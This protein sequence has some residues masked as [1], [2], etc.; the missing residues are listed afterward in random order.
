MVNLSP[1][2]DVDSPWNS[3]Y[4]Y[5]STSIRCF[6]HIHAWEMSGIPVM[7]TVGPMKGHLGMEEYKSAFTHEGEIAKAGYH[8]VFLNDYHVWA[9]LTSTC[10]V[11]MH[12][13]TFPESDAAYLIFDT[14]AFLANSPMDSSHVRKVSDTEI[15]GMSLMAPSFSHRRNNQAPVWFVAQF[16]KPMS[17]FGGWVDKQ[18]ITEP[19]DRVSGKDA[20]VYI[21]FH[22]AEGEQI[23]VKVAISYTGLEAAR[24]NLN[25]ELA[26]WDFDKV[27]EDSFREWEDELSHIRVSGGT[28]AQ[29]TKFYTDLWH[30]QLGRRTVSDVDGNY[31][32]HTGE[33]LRTGQA[34]LDRHGKPWAHH[35]YDSWWG[36]HW[37]LNILWSLA[38]PEVMDEFCNTMISMYKDGGL[39]DRGATGGNYSFVMIGDPSV[40]LFATAYNKGIRNYDTVTAY[41]A[42]RKNAFIGGDRDHAGYEQQY[43]ATGGGMK[44]Y[45][46]RGYV[47]YDRT[48]GVGFHN[49]ATSAM[50]LEYAYQDW[51]L[52]QIAKNMGKE[53]DYAYFTQRAQNYRNVWNPESRFMQPRL[54]DGSFLK[55]FNPAKGGRDIGF[56]EANAAIYSHYVPHDITGLM[57]LFGGQE[58]YVKR[59]N[60]Q[61]EK[62]QQNGFRHN[63]EIEFWTQYTNQPGT[64]MAHIFNFAGAPW[65][66]Q[67]WVRKV[68][69]AFSDITPYGG[70]YDDEDQGQMGALGVLLAIGLFEEDGGAAAK[71]TYE[72]TSPI[73]DK[74]EIA[75]NPDYYPGKTFSIITRNNS[76]ENMYIQSA[77]LNGEEWN[78]YWFSHET[79]ANGGTLELVLGPEPNYHWGVKE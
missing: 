8:K 70:Y 51:C 26:H 23:Q 75:L 13:Y 63:D 30:A 71:P 61:F 47:P 54:L 76:P 27:K 6:S 74:V 40:S 68:K 9:E 33:T 19:I 60:E 17:A 28:E 34:P 5:G 45:L 3:S 22:T 21:R 66:S 31:P 44:Y 16:D 11:G 15:E 58:T 57:E 41:E 36:S 29:K 64:G 43:P 55:E 52:A 56:C 53:D 67:K 62:G 50:T 4:L 2:T 37:S 72:I 18:L 73:F 32:D 79:L 1:D 46:D 48:D 39:I 69:E 20:G 78:R 7:P 10:R 14:G 77:K 12:R 24:K 59:L 42:L 35:N 25:A 65:L 38:Y 49:S